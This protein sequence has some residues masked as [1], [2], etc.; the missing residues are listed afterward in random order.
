MKRAM[1]VACSAA[2]GSR[3]AR[4]NG[5]SG[6]RRAAARHGPRRSRRPGSCTPRP[7]QVGLRPLRLRKRQARGQRGGCGRRF[8]RR[9]GARI[10]APLEGLA[11]SHRQQCEKESGLRHSKDHASRRL[12]WCG[13]EYIAPPPACHRPRG[14]GPGLRPVGL[15][16]PGPVGKIPP[17]PAVRPVRRDPPR[18]RPKPQD[19]PD[20]HSG[21]G[22][23]RPGHRRRGASQPGR[24]RGR[25]R[26]RHRL[27]LQPDRDLLRG[28][29]L[30]GDALQRWLSRFHGLDAALVRPYVYS[31][32][33]KEAVCHLFE[34][35]AGLDSM[36]LAS[37]RSSAR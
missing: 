21:T 20:R 7:G 24:A 28:D 35:A 11:P 19:S 13:L 5:S 30:D 15:P 31:Y 4:R 12:G 33:D 6:C 3:S 26:G 23:L 22:E 9:S 25:G 1:R 27:D 8:L 37:P 29:A 10:G 14:H 18:P 2:Y 32:R 17:S 34:V 36:I 16:S